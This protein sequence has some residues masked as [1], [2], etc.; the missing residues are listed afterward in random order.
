MKIGLVSS[1][2]PFINGGA[3][4]IVEWLEE[5]LVEHGHQVERF[6]LPFED[7]PATMLGQH[8]AFRLLKIESCDRLI[9]F[10][11]PAHVIDHPDKVLW[12]IHHI[13]AFYDLWDTPHRHLPDDADTRALR[14]DVTAIDNRTLREARA[15]YTNSQVVADRL[16]AFNGIEAAPL[17]PPIFRPE[18]FTPGEHGDEIVM[19]SRIEPHKR[20][21]LAILAMNHVRT[22][23][24]LRLVGRASSP[25]HAVTIRTLIQENGLERRVIFDDAWATEADKARHLTGCLA[26]AY[27]PKDEDSYGYPSLEAGHSQKAVITTSDSG[28]VLELVQDSVNGFVTAPEPEA[29]AQAF[30]IL[31]RDR[32]S[33]RRMGEANLERMAEL[34][35]DWDHVVERLTAA[36]PPPPAAAG[37]P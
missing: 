27:L 31:F 34:K 15:V 3:R 29:L 7:D 21:E 37:R 9:C 8:L 33:A 6:Y 14:A 1:Y 13:R 35:I 11:P 25:E 22:G 4:F 2:V 28:G 18:R 10:R 36:Y 16:K 30:D 26:T 19:I 24:K 32:L 20:Q 5:K 23:V 17:Y 12:F